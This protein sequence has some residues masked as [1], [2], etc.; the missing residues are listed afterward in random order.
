MINNSSILKQLEEQKNN[1]AKRITVLHFANNEALEKRYGEAGKKRCFEDAV[2]HIDFLTEALRLDFTEIYGQYIVWV[3]S[4][5]KSRNIPASDLMEN[6]KYIQVAI[7]EILGKEAL[8]EVT[9]YMR[10]ALD[11]LSQK[12]NLVNSF[13]QPDNP[14]RNEVEQ[15]TALL[16]NSKRKEAAALIDELINNG[17]TVKSI[18]QHIFRVSQYEVGLLWQ[19]NK[20]TVA[21]EHF[22]TAAT[23]L[24]M[25]NLYKYIFFT[26]KKGKLMLACSISGELHE[27]GIRMVA[28]FFEMDGWDTYYMGANMP[29]Q[30]LEMALIEHKAD[31]LAISVT[32]L[33][34]VSKAAA[35]IQSL[36][37]NEK[38]KNLK[39]LVGGY[40]FI[41]N[42]QLWQKIGADGFADTAENAITL[43]NSIVEQYD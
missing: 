6:I 14:L 4:M 22:C 30:H 21:H 2:Y 32:L 41:E 26:E 8:D 15:Y 31:L 42:P 7:E 20:I 3:A 37:A 29:V 18:Y 38:L 11:K 13:I 23:Q 1:L 40:P 35:L 24:I 12:Q 16:L 25:S 27:M 17:T 19:N 33:T 10:K 43:A 5:L 28:D 36:R 34:H 9:P 39:I